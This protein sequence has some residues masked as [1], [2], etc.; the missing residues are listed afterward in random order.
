MRS[1]AT[2]KIAKFLKSIVITGAIVGFSLVFITLFITLFKHKESFHEAK[3][4]DRTNFL[5]FKDQVFVT[6][7]SAGNFLVVGADANTLSPIDTKGYVPQI[8]KDKNHIFCG[9]KAIPL[10]NPN[11]IISSFYGYINGRHHAYYCDYSTLNTDISIFE[12]FTD[13]YKTEFDEDKPLTYHNKLVDLKSLSPTSLASIFF[14]YAKDDQAVYYKGQKIPNADSNTVKTVNQTILGS[15]D[16]VSL[17]YIQDQ[18]HIFYKDK[19]LLNAR[20]ENTKIY[21]LDDSHFDYAYDEYNDQFFIYDM[22]FPRTIE[23]SK[24]YNLYLKTTLQND[25]PID[26]MLTQYQTDH[27][28]FLNLSNHHTYHELFYN[29]QGIFYWD[30]STQKLSVA[31]P[32][33]FDTKTVKALSNGFIADQKNSYFLEAVEIRHNSRYNK[34]VKY[35]ETV[36]IK[37]ANISANSWQKITEIRNENQSYSEGILWKTGNDYYFESSNNKNNFYESTLYKVKN[38][39]LLLSGNYRNLKKELL[40]PITNQPIACV[41]KTSL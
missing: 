26:K 21:H 13:L 24:A 3:R 22:P 27:L 20:P 35:I 39:D 29:D 5:I 17:D 19:Q 11:E 4:I 18:F 10:L 32:I 36:M 12:Q 1:G 28:N 7:P 6:I 38:V 34:K 15:S 33:P 16:Q 2:S 9:N 40:L 31:C 37:L 25:I 8:A 23:T 41:A 14:A 30:S